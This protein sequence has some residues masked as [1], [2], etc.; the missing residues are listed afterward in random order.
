MKLDRAV[1]LERK[2]AD[3]LRD[4]YSSAAVFGQSHE[5]VMKEKNRLVTGTEMYQRGPRWLKSYLH[6]YDAALFN[7]MYSCQ[8]DGGK[9]PLMSVIYGP[10]G[11]MFAEGDDSWLREDTAYKMA[12]TN[13]HIWRK[14]W[15]EKGEVR[16]W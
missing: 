12:M 15:M 6:G 4:C 2:L 14:R 3:R 5:W 8:I 1:K 7:A 9:P 10:D 11:R 16:T 13:Q